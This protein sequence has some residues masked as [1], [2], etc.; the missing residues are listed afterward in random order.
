MTASPSYVLARAEA[1]CAAA[2]LDYRFFRYRWFEFRNDRVLH[3]A[4]VARERWSVLFDL[5]RDPPPDAAWSNGL[6]ADELA[7]LAGAA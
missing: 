6:T 3:Q 2:L 7:V 5:L 4:L 1:R